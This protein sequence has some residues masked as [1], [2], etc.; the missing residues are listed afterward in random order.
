[1]DIYQAHTGIHPI[2]G[3]IV[4]LKEVV[5]FFRVTTRSVHIRW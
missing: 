4:D 1:M 2:S 3:V 5:F